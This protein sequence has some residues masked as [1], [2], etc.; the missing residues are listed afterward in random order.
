M[1][2]MVLELEKI[3]DPMVTKKSTKTVAPPVATG[4]SSLI[5]SF[6]FSVDANCTCY[7]FEILPLIFYRLSQLPSY[8]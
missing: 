4:M 5:S 1:T 8:S 7:F 2:I 3:S 6:F